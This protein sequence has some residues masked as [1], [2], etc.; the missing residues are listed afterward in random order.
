LF[1]LVKIFII[2]FIGSTFIRVAVAR[3]RITQIVKVYWG[4]A[5]LMALLGLLLITIDLM[6]VV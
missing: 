3:F 2:V 4:Y 1:F 5:S 6:G